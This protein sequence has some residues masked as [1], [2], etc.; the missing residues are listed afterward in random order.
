MY[1]MDDG[2]FWTFFL[3]RTRVKVSFFSPKKTVWREIVGLL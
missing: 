3:P 2:D 1:I